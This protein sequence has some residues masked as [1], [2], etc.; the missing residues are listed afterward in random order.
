MITSAL[1]VKEGRGV[2]IIDIPG[3]YLHIYMDK[4]GKQIIIM[5][6][7]GK[8]VELVVML[9]PK[10]RRKYVTYDSKGD[11]ILYVE[12]NKALYGL[13]KIELLFYNKFRKDIEAYGFVINPYDPCV[14]N[15]M[16][17]SNQMTVTWHVDNLKIYHK[18]PYH[19]TKFDSYLS[20]IYG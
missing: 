4:Y 14:A 18:E 5:L 13:L 10:L 16:I 19:I 3:A 1:E 6:L 9:D 8:L 17:K 7:K 12:M 20:I 2:D 15:Y 11:I